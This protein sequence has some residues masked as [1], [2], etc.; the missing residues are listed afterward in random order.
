EAIRAVAGLPTA[1]SARAALGSLDLPTDR[2]LDHALWLTT[3]DLADPWLAAL[4]NGSIKTDGSEKGLLFGLSAVPPEKASQALAQLLEKQPLAHDG[5]GPW[6]EL[7]GQGGEQNELRKLFE[8]AVSGGFDL[9][10]TI[11]ALTALGD[12]ARLRRVRPTGD[13]QPLS[14]LLDAG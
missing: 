7:I 6:I 12:A 14:K 8:Q 2:F 13:L 5:H 1:E 9:P 3:N 10:A 4:A 11:R